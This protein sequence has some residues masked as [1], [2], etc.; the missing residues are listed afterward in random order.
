MFHVTGAGPSAGAGLPP[1]DGP[2]IMLAKFPVFRYNIKAILKKQS[3]GV[4]ELV[5]VV[6]SKSC[7][8]IHRRF[9]RT[10]GITAYFQLNNS[11][12]F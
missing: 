1:A 9:C 5:D 10:L 8:S 7:S 12:W 11:I 4:M 2:K 3:A 6:D